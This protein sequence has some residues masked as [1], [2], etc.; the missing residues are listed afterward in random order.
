MESLLKMMGFTLEEMVDSLGGRRR[1]TCHG[2]R[3]A[4]LA[5]RISSEIVAFCDA[6]CHQK[7]VHFGG[8]WL[9][10]QPFEY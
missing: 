5:A 6:L 8:F 3:P 4:L 2:R 10:E 7:Q 9:K 1:A